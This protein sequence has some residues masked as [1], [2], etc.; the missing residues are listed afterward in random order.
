MSY[1]RG[2][3]PFY[4]FVL[5]LA[6]FF[7]KLEG[8]SS[9][10]SDL[11]YDYEQDYD[12]KY[13][14]DYEEPAYVNAFVEVE[15]SEKPAMEA[16]YLVGNAL[17][18]TIRNTYDI[19]YLS[20]D[21]VGMQGVP[22]EVYSYNATAVQ[23]EFSLVFEYDDAQLECAEEDLGIL[24]Y[25]ESDY[26]Y[27]TLTNFETDYENNT[28]TVP[29]EQLGT[30]ILEDMKT[31]ESVWDGTYVYKENELPQEP[32]CHW[33]DAF[34]YEDI[35]ALAD[36]AFFEVHNNYI[37]AAGESEEVTGDDIRA[38]E[39]HITTIEQLAGLVKLVNE[40][41]SFYGCD[42]YLDA[43]LDLAGY[44]W[45]PIGWYYPADNGYYGKDFPF[46][47]RFFGN[48]HTI[49]NM[50]IVAPDHSD[51]GM[52]GRTLQSFEVHDL[53]LIDCYIE[54]KF[55]VG[56]I[57]GDNINYGDDFDMTNCFVSGIVKGRKDVG[58]LVGSSA[59]LKL[60]D[61]YAVMEEGS[62]MELVGD[63][64]SG[65]LENCSINDEVAQEVLSQ[66]K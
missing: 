31:W 12:Y 57:L 2:T 27:E 51:L 63:L 26:W 60:Q 30:Y 36:T 29:V 52:F 8:N 53:A 45:A 1:S 3:N 48:G 39:Y 58:A 21:V 11:L 43:D 64:R 41:N 34:A 65:Y 46:E 28:V 59:Y 33:H 23:N 9:K 40:G 13:D 66:Y 47:G 14:Y 24:W 50:S 37:I 16:A 25:N 7:A 22:I 55:Y 54:G 44:E 10:L 6:M 32:E 42:F 4:I 19:D 49:Y 35:E 20:R 62:T 17:G 15:E 38:K 18:Y 5:I 61:C 56:G